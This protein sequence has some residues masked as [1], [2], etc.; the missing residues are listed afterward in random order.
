MARFF[1]DRPIFAIVISLFLILA[2]ILSMLGLPVSQFPNIAPPTV[3][4]SGV[5]P[6]ASAEVVENSVVAPID[7]QINGVAGMKYIKAV[8]GNDGSAVITVTFDLERDVDI[9]AVETQTRVSQIESSLPSEVNDIGV[10]VTKASPDTLLYIALFSPDKT[11]DRLFINNYVYNYIVDPIKRVPGVGNVQV[12]GAEFGM[13]IWLQP[14]KMAGLAL[15]TSDVLQAIREQ[16]K[17]A[18]AGQ[19][20]QPPAYS[21]S[22]F[23][24]SLQLDG[25]LTELSE[26]ENIILR[27]HDDGSILRLR[28]VARVELGAKSY[29][30]TSGY[31]GGEASVFGISLAPGAN[32]LETADGLKSTLEQLSASFPVGIDYDITYDSSEFVKASIEEVI[33]TLFEALVLVFLVVFLFIQTGKATLIPMLAVPVSL[34]ATF[35]CYQFLGFSINTLSLFG[36]VLAI[37]IV[38]DDAIVVVEAVEHKMRDEGLSALAATKASMDEVSGALVAMTLVLAAVFIPMAFVPGV[39]GQLYKQFAITIAVSTMFSVLVA[40][41]LTP[42]LCAKLLKQRVEGASPNLISRFFTAFN[43]GFD[44]LTDGYIRIVRTGVKKPMLVVIFM[45]VTILSISY[46]FRI[47]PTGFV[48]NEDTGS[49]FVQVA[50][51]EGASIQRTSSAMDKLST[52]IQAIAGVESLVTI[53]GYDLISGTAAPNSGLVITRLLPWGE[54]QSEQLKAASIIN[55]VRALNRSLPEAIVY[56]FNP[57]ALPGFGAA[58]GFSMMLQAR[59]SQSPEQLANTTQQFIQA[60]R[61]RPEIL[62]INTSFSTSTPNYHLFVDRDKA[63]KL[64]I[65]IDEVYATLQTFLGGIEVN[66][67]TNFGKNYKVHVQ[68]DADFRQDIST[69][70]SLF[71]RGQSG[72]MTPL[73]SIVRA[74]PSVGPRFMLRYNLYPSAELTGEPAPGYSSGQALQALREVADEILDSSYGYEWSGQTREEVDSGSTA[75]Q[76]L[77]LSILVV[78]LFLAALYES[79]SIPLSVLLAA[80]FGIIGAFAAILITQTDFNVYGQIGLVTLVGL[81]AKNA[82][83]IVEFAKLYREQGQSLQDAALAAAKLRFRP[84]LMTALAFILGVIPLVIASGAGAASKQA[85]GMSVFGGMIAAVFFGLLI[86]PG[87]F[88]IVERVAERIGGKSGLYVPTQKI[89]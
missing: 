59:G 34:I 23:Q 24:Y 82:I 15:T 56:A 81:S 83:L 16:N 10:A 39:T 6:G 26:F 42:A 77:I 63:K 49:F 84:I 89:K 8:S 53:V 68:A 17:Q 46:L 64:G 61:Q 38:V 3:K 55:Q 78:F 65:P 52:Q 66:D 20:G 14:E 29:A 80:P 51:P 1:I 41:T 33:Y 60:A 86:V 71:M 31:N 12:F 22:G 32:A 73:D 9:A 50:L 88:V 76:V 21:Q 36:M 85:V 69:L 47:T 48:P 7:S 5:Y 30:T 54:R 18:A 74:E 45:L 44:K 70:S 67:F 2:G 37:G 27:V 72:E 57:P 75:V 35:I 62:T 43:F 13:R 58:S 11:Y 87:L 19:L 4:I 40:L 28:D 79:W 25:K